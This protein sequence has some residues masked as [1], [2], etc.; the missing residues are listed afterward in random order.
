MVGHPRDFLQHRRRPHRCQR[1]RPPGEGAMGRHQNRWYLYNGTP[2]ECLG[3]DPPDG[4]FILPFNLIVPQGAGAGNLTAKIIGMGRPQNRDRAADLGP[5][6]SIEGMGMNDAADLG[7]RFIQFQMG[8][9]ASM[10]GTFFP[11]TIAPVAKS[12]TI[13]SRGFSRSKS[14]PEGFMTTRPPSRSTPDA[15]P[16]AKGAKR[17]RGKAILAAQTNSFRSSNIRA[18]F[19]SADA[20]HRPPTPIFL[21]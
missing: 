12:I 10:E 17:Y 6:R 19:S 16:Q 15:L 7:K 20:L 11:S 4:L 21:P 9:C 8:R 14:N 2:L 3:D 18:P 5:C 1:R 13:M